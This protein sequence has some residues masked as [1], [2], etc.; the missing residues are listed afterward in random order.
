MRIG[1][2][3]LAQNETARQQEGESRQYEETFHE[4]LLLSG[5]AV[6]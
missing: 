4:R 3:R 1:H 2:R 6:P 5:L